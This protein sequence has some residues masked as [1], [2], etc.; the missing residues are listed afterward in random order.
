MNIVTAVCAVVLS[1]AL[2]AW[3]AYCAARI[4]GIIKE[5]IDLEQ[6]TSG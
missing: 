4:F 3:I 1:L 5:D 6:R 2:I